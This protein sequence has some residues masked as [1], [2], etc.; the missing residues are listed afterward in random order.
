MAY[1]E[2][3]KALTVEGEGG[4]KLREVEREQTVGFFSKKKIWLK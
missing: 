1:T 4:E 2:I 3:T